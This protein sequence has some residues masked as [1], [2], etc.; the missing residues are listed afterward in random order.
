MSARQAGSVFGPSS[1]PRASQQDQTG[2]DQ[3]GND[4]QSPSDERRPRFVGPTADVQAQKRH[5]DQE[6]DPA[7]EVDADHEGHEQMTC[8]C[9]IPRPM[10]ESC[11]Q[12]SLRGGPASEGDKKQADVPDQQE[13][14]GQDQKKLFTERV[15]DAQREHE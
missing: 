14:C 2:R 10:G 4:G 6:P 5:E 1:V 13:Q 11:P 3:R 7:W 15:V 12:E 8:G 9:S